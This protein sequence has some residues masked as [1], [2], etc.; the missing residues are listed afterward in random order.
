[1]TW[2]FIMALL[3]S[4]SYTYASV[5][6]ESN[7]HASNQHIDDMSSQSL[8]SKTPRLLES[9]MPNHMQHNTHQKIKQNNQQDTQQQG[10][11]MECC[12]QECSCLTGTCASVTLTHFTSATALNVVSGSSGF[13]L[14]QVQNAFLA[15]LRK[16]PIIG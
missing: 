14:F 15:S 2:V 10:M 3:F 4:Q 8:A 1:M 12:D 6:C 13:Y 5:P 7:A 9:D 11:P 16:P